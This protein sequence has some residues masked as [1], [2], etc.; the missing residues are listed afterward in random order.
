MA[1]RSAPAANFRRDIEGLR[2]IAVLIVV[3]FHC[4]IPGFSGGFT[5]VDVFFAVSG[6]LM[7]GLLA[8]E[9]RNT[10]NLS[11]LRFYARRARRLLPASALT[12]LTTLIIGALVMAP[13][14]LAFAGRAGRST[15]LH[16]SNIF[17]AT[18]SADYFAPS[19][20]TNPLLNMWSLDLEEQFYLLWPLLLMVPLLMW[21]STRAL[22]VILSAVTMAS[23]IVCVRLSGTDTTFAFY[24]LPA[25]AWEF[26]VG[27]LVALLPLAKLRVPTGCWIAL[28]W[29]GLMAILWAGHATSVSQFPGLLALVP[30]T[31]TVVVLAACSQRPARGADV[32]L[33]ARPLQK[34]GA[35]SYSWY[36]W[37]WPFLVLATAFVPGLSAT[38]KAL[39]ALG[40]LAAAELTYRLVENPI[41][42]HPYLV[43]RP[44]V[45]LGLA[46]VVTAGTLSAAML[47]MRLASHLA[48]TP[49]LKGIAQEAD[50]IAS[51]PRQ[52]CVSLAG[53]PEVKTCEFGSVSSRTN[54]V[55]FGDSHA[56]EWFNALLRM[57][58][59]RGVKL[60]TVIKSGCPS[61]DVT[62]G[63]PGDREACQRWRSQAI[64][65]VVAMRPSLVI[66]A[67]Y[68]G[69]TNERK[70]AGT[71]VDEWMNGTKRTLV[72]LTTSGLPVAVIRD[73]PSFN[74]DI[75]ACLARSVRSAWY[76]SISCDMDRTASL[77]PAIFAAEK[78]AAR[79]LPNVQFIDLT[80]Q[81]CG[82]RVCWA[83]KQGVVMYRDDNHLTGRFA[84]TLT[85]EV[86]AQI[87]PMLNAPAASEDTY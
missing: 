36:L 15:A 6:Y 30:V 83:E 44:A 43:A 38:S 79:G 19:V 7:T 20:E 70:A 73:N 47:S 72:T 10:Q 18:N 14:E 31:G 17:F 78:V 48:D 32:L 35:I 12:L 75:P 66:I 54:V 13:Q 25:R 22:L 26:G 65:R 49:V 9:V 3:A 23:L 53:S 33:A 8:A 82:E 52:Q 29:S 24:Q 86:T 67:N 28:G 64:D 11:L 2:A 59:R 39:V 37:H 81:L 51:M 69:L 40:A 4:R 1:N 5:G 61:V 50:D 27:G 42:F 87:L 60:T 71:S 21:R 80:D 45:T 76:R 55:L 68:S 74:I 77:N 62:N 85:E 41:R 16:V 63:P 56:I 34:L 84:D 46:V 58:E 57:A